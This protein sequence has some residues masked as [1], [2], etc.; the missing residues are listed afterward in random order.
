MQSKLH[1]VNA[2]TFQDHSQCQQRITELEGLLTAKDAAI[3]SEQDKIQAYTGTIKLLRDE[4]HK[5]GAVRPSLS[6]R[7]QQLGFCAAPQDA[8][9][10]TS[11]TTVDVRN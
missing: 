7:L 8:T 10:A 9:C 1:D 6:E 11:S 3:Q 4:L 2:G 5:K